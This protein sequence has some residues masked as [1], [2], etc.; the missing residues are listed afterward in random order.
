MH[1]STG[2]PDNG[3]VRLVPRP[4]PNSDPTPLPPPI[5]H[6][7]MVG[8]ELVAADE[9]GYEISHLSMHKESRISG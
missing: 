5:H 6:E 1:Q 8:G 4:R 3:I 9:G 7:R 2:Q